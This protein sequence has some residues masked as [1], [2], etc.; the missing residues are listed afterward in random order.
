MNR[1]QKKK[2]LKCAD[3]G[4]T[5][6]REMRKWFKWMKWFER[7]QKRKWKH[8]NSKYDFQHYL[9]YKEADECRF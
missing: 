5:S 9:L 8:S 3:Y 6:C 7:E 4:Y 2:K 1:R